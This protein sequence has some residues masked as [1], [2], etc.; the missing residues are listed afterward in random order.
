MKRNL[1]DGV[2]T[3]AD[4]AQLTDAAIGA[5]MD[6][7][8]AG[9]PV[10]DVLA[11]PPR[12][13]AEQ[14]REALQAEGLA[15]AEAAQVAATVTREDLAPDVVRAV[16]SSMSLN[17]PLADEIAANFDRRRDLM[18]I[19]PL[20][21]GAVALLVLVLRVKRV[22]VSKDAGVEVDLAPLKV[23]VLKSIV[24]FVSGLS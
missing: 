11:M 7:A 14:L 19:D 20:T 23:D 6:Q 3:D 4:L 2:H 16:L 15:P 9:G 8:D 13:L 12:V 10:E 1:V 22:R 21:I 24:G 5:L 17:E 18:A